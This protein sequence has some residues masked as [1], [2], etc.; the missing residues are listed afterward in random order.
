MISIIFLCFDISSLILSKII[1][2]ASIAIP[3]V[4]IIPAIQGND[5]VAFIHGF[6]KKAMMKSRFKII[7]KLANNP[8]PL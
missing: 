6:D 8:K 7:A 2:F 3:T 4:N 1:T 5:N